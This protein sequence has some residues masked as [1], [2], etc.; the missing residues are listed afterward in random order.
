MTQGHIPHDSE[1]AAKQKWEIKLRRLMF[2]NCNYTPHFKHDILSG[3]IPPR[4]VTFSGIW[5]WVVDF[6]LRATLIWLIRPLYALRKRLSGS[7]ILSG[8]RGEEKKF[9]PASNRTVISRPYSPPTGQYA[10]LLAIIPAWYVLPKR[11]HLTCTS[12]VKSKFFP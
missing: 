2:F 5:M 3:C 8:R 11:M 12:W 1:S 9:Y 6:I 10:E 7:R 4:F